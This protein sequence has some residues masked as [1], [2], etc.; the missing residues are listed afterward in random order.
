MKD[1]ILSLNCRLVMLVLISASILVGC[2][3][4]PLA[5]ELT[6]SPSITSTEKTNTR[7]V[8]PSL[9]KVSST[10][11]IP[12]TAKSTLIPTSEIKAHQRKLELEKT[13]TTYGSYLSISKDSR[14][15]ASSDPERVFTID[16]NN[17]DLVAEFIK[18]EASAMG[19]GSVVFSPDGK[20]L[21]A[22]VNVEGKQGTESEF[23]LL[24]STSLKLLEK[25]PFNGTITDLQYSPNGRFV[26]ATGS[27]RGKIYVWDIKN[28]KVT[29]LDSAADQLAFSP[30]DPLLASGETVYQSGP[31]V[32]LWNL[33]DFSSR[34]IFGVDIDPNSTIPGY[35]SSV[36]FS[37]DG[38]FLAAVINGNLRFWDMVANK[39]VEPS[40]TTSDSLAKAIYS[41][42]GYLATLNQKGE[43]NIYDPTSGTV[44]GTVVVKGVDD[45]VYFELAFGME[46]SPDG[47]QLFTGAYDIPIQIW[48]IPQ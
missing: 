27:D 37:P 20:Y 45:P 28:K 17:G 29:L 11:T 35:A 6:S 1:K 13:F 5:F 26:A 41:A 23:Y 10:L 39:E 7:T 34:G 19:M 14:L 25:H 12:T 36:S 3:M 2:Q 15:I 31:V 22:E 44:L 33:K 4:S 18:P 21:A 9:D 46:F 38:H 42:K 43:I 8:T 30:V 16:V 47:E 24:D 40:L 32:K 48:K